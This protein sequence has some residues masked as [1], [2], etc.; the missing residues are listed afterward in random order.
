[1]GIL[2]KSP[3]IYI[4]MLTKNS[5]GRVTGDRRDCGDSIV[6]RIYSVYSAMVMYVSVYWMAVGVVVTSYIFI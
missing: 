3:C 1:M 6:V 5:V 4:Y 2:G